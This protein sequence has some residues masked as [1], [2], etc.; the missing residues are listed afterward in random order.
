M[1]LFVSLFEKTPSTQENPLELF[2]KAKTREF[3]Q[4]VKILLAVLDIEYLYY[5]AVS[6]AI[7]TDNK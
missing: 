7:K 3:L 4:V 5:S 1:W 2:T 6:V